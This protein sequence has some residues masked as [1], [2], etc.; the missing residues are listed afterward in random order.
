MVTTGPAVPLGAR[1]LDLGWKMFP[2][3]IQRILNKNHT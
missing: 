2:N 1:L 3:N